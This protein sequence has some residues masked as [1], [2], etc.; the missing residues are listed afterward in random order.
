MTPLDDLNI[1]LRTA[2]EAMEAP[3]ANELIAKAMDV[4]TRDYVGSLEDAMSLVPIGSWF[5]WNHFGFEFT[6]NVAVEGQPF[7]NAVDYYGPGHR[8]GR[9]ISFEAMGFDSP[10]TRKALPRLV[11][12]AVLKA[13]RAAVLKAMARRDGRPYLVQT[14]K[15][16]LLVTP[17]GT[18][19]EI[20]A[21]KYLTADCR[22]VP[23]DPDI[24]GP[25][26]IEDPD[27]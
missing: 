10:D 15:G 12:K 11:C 22:L 26:R 13:R 25:A 6:P 16:P 27:A 5:R 8:E 4:P 1:S 7:S 21:D 23:H 2:L 20:P 18:F 9:P 3:S 14:G 17:E 19:G 24:Y